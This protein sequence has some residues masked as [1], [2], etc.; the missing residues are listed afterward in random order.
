MS[1]MDRAR[2]FVESGRFDELSPLL[3]DCVA[4]A[5]IEGLHATQ[6]LARDMYGGETYNLMI[7]M[8]AAYCLLAW[9][10]DGLKALTENAAN[11]ST[12]K[13]FT[14]A[15]KLLAGAAGGSAPQTFLTLGSNERLQEAVSRAGVNW[16]TLAPKARRHLNELML[17]IEHDEDAAM[18]AATSLQGLALMDPDAISNLSRA[19]ALRSIAVGPKVIQSYEDIVAKTDE[20]ERTY[21]TFLEKHPLLINPRA[22]QVWSQPDL[23][24]R[25]IPDFVLRT[26]DNGYIIVEIE[27]PSKTLVTQNYQLSSHA[28]HA[29]S[30]VLQYQ[31]YLRTHA[32]EASRSFPAFSH[33]AGLVVVGREET[34]DAGQKAVLRLEN[35]SRRDITI[36]GFDTL[37]NSAKAVT[38]NLINGISRTVFNTRLQ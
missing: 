18:Y 20:E 35:L 29:I 37:A 32:C 25:F 17:S 14:L 24:G 22:F 27:T 10:E 15:F 11:E 8:P 31:E 33:P 6:L 28:T 3:L 9:A 13:N 16:V 36:V 1:L 12:F 5:D 21:Q 23:H 4:S 38:S 7:K 2:R 34:L 19:L 30:Q 26:N